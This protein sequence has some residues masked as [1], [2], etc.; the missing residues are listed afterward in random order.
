MT[1]WADKSLLVLGLGETGLSLVRWLSAQ[2]A[3]VRVADSRER[4]PG[5]DVPPQVRDH[6]PGANLCLS[7]SVVEQRVWHLGLRVGEA[8]ALGR[9]TEFRCQPV[10]TR[11]VGGGALLA[12]FLVAVMHMPVCAV[13]GASLLTTLVSSV[14]GVTSFELIDVIGGLPS[15]RPDWLLGAMFGLGGPGRTGWAAEP[16][17]SKLKAQRKSI[18]SITTRLSFFYYFLFF[19]LVL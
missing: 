12:P 8:V 13:A 1:Q 9:E 18:P 15:V 17:G 10:R 14:A 4:P 7:R 19:E 11:G 6:P 16:Q 5:L 2:G 3:R